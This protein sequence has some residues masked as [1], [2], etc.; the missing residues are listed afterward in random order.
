MTPIASVHDHQDVHIAVLMRR[1]VGVRAEKYN[2]VRLKAVRDL[3]REPA[4]DGS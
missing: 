3:A 2:F 4:D 1:A